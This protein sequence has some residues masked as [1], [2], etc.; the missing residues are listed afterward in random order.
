MSSHWRIWSMRLTKSDA[1]FTRMALGRGRWKQAVRPIRGLFSMSLEERRAAC[2]REVMP[3]GFGEV[4]RF[5]RSAAYRIN[6]SVELGQS[7]SCLGKKQLRK[8]RLREEM[9]RTG[10]RNWPSDSQAHCFALFCYPTPH[11]LPWKSIRKEKVEGNNGYDSSSLYEAPTMCTALLSPTQATD[12]V[13]GPA[14]GRRQTESGER[15]VSLQAVWYHSQI[16]ERLARRLS[17]TSIHKEHLII[18]SN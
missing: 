2:P 6:W 4:D 5:Q 13:V 15:T 17:Q 10:I 7:Y 14:Q 9:A 11:W 16:Q 1:P 8:L 18:T 3:I 12:R